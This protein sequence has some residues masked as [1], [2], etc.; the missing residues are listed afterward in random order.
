MLA[1]VIY[2]LIIF[3][4]KLGITFLQNSS[5]EFCTL[6]AGISSPALNSAAIPSKLRTSIIFV[7]C[8]TTVSGSPTATFSPWMSDQFISE[9]FLLVF[10]SVL[11]DAVALLPY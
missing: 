4:R 5:S 2:L 9:R 8:L 10:P 1:A 7:S 3:Q 11:S 6:S